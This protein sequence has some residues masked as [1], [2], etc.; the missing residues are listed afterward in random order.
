MRSVCTLPQVEQGQLN[1]IQPVRKMP[2]MMGQPKLHKLLFAECVNEQ[3]VRA[4]AESLLRPERV[5]D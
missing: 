2:T 4:V 5:F 1:I 3:A